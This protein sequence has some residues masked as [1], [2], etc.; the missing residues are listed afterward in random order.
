MKNQSIKTIL[1]VIILTLFASSCGNDDNPIT[2]P[3]IVPTSIGAGFLAGNGEEEIPEQN[4]VI[5]NTADWQVLKNKMNT[6]NP[7]TDYF[8]ETEIDF[9]QFRIIAAFDR[10]RP[11]GGH[12][13]AVAAV[14]DNPDAINVIISRT[15]PEDIGT[16]VITQPYHIVKIPVSPKPIVFN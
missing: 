12:S 16:A 14:L 9:S 7:E 2:P 8:T 13:I 15:F 3:S 11:M 10:V 6:V 5:T 4:V 1:S